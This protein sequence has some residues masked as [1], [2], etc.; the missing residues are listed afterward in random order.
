MPFRVFSSDL[1]TESNAGFYYGPG[2][3]RRSRYTP[4]DDIDI[5]DAVPVFAHGQVFWVRAPCTVNTVLIGTPSPYLR[6][7]VTFT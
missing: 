4:H 2:S 5:G 6:T 7:F 1:F 3:I